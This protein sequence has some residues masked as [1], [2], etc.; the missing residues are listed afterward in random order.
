MSRDDHGPGPSLN[1]WYVNA[2]DGTPDQQATRTF[3]FGKELV[4]RGHRVT[5]FASSFSHYRHRE[6]RLQG[7]ELSR[8]EDYEGVTLRWLRTWPYRRND[9]R[10]VLNMIG[11]ACVA[12]WIGLRLRVAPDVI[13]GP[14]VPIL[15]GLA[16]FLLSRVRQ[17]RF[18]FEVRDLWPQTL[19]DLG[20]LS[21][22]GVLTRLL[23]W[24]ERL[25]YAKADRIITV[26]P[27]AHEYI[28]GLGVPRERVIWI[29]NGVDFSRYRSTRAYDGG[30]PDR[31]VVMYVGGHAP[32]QGIDVILDAAARLQA[33]SVEWVR[34]VLIGDGPEKPRLVER[35]RALG[36]CNLEFRDLIPKKAVPQALEEADALIA[37]IRDLPVLRFGINP[38]KLFEYM[39]AGRPVVFG[40]RAPNNPVKEA[41]AGITV[42][43]EDPAALCDAIRTLHHMPPEARRLLGENGRRY[44]SE[45]HDIEKLTDRLED[46][47]RGQL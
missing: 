9:W 28:A 45:R 23:R 12:F 40:I 17:S 4:R 16:A 6:E 43:P 7:W 20:V 26:L 13:V 15:A 1:I 31:F 11:H 5:I 14:S 27:Y 44:V 2:Y 19:I 8:E 46:V 37:I 33:E 24:I 41:N 38:N 42:P 34:F 47:F 22:H 35:A 18:Y 30:H 29:P 10:R 36:L 3:D 32:Y 21:E 39:A 25:L